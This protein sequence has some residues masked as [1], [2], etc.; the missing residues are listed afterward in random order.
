M[1]ISK[2]K[3]SPSL[4]AVT[5]LATIMLTLLTAPIIARELGPSG[6]GVYAACLS[7]MTLMPSVVGLGLPMV[8]RRRAVKESGWPLLRAVYLVLP[9]LAFPGLAAGV[10]V[11]ICLV[12]ELSPIEEKI[13]IVGMAVSVL[14]VGTLAAQSI[15]LVRSKY[16][17]VSILLATQSV[18]VSISIFIAWPLGKLSVS[19]LLVSFIA[20]TALSCV[21]GVFFVYENASG[22][23]A[24]IRGLLQEGSRFSVSQL[25]EVATASIYPVLAV[26]AVGAVNAGYF[27]VSMTIASLPLALGFAIGSVAFRDVAASDAGSRGDLIAAY[28]RISLVLGVGCTLALMM[29][30]PTA[31]PIIFGDE[32]VPA[33]NV[34]MLMV[35]GCA[36]L[37]I[38]YV[39]NQILGAVGNGFAMTVAQ[40][41]G[42]L[43]GVVA[44]YA[45]GSKWGAMGASGAV[46]VGWGTTCIVA[47]AFLRVGG[48]QVIPRWSDVRLTWKVLAGGR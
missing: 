11:A 13:F 27:A 23:I 16:I 7:A 1:L 48:I 5:R 8:V 19:W 34:T 41:A 17:G 3:R 29:I 36:L 42:I 44:I 14:F 33:I 39:S 47:A 18:V 35:T 20:G 22:P 2:I 15:L 25:A 37:L 9:F 45:L 28:F 4:L 31:I 10:I 24:R 6:R 38:N 26:T 46:L 12:P 40:L 32:F 30:V 43:V 21:L